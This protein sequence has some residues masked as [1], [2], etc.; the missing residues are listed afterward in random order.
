MIEADIIVMLNHFQL[1]PWGEYI[2][3]ESYQQMKIPSAVKFEIASEAG[4]AR[5]PKR[6]SF[7]NR[8][9]DSID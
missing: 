3:N 4:Q 6:L 1:I 2:R 9:L 5:Y 7:L 8:R